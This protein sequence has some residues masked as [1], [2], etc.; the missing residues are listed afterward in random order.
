MLRSMPLAML[1]VAVVAVTAQP[2]FARSP[3]GP[4]KEVTGFKGFSWVGP[5]NHGW[6]YKT[7]TADEGPVRSGAEAD[8]FEIRAGD[9]GV[10]EGYDLCK[11]DREHVAWN[12]T[13]STKIGVPVAYSFSIYIPKDTPTSL[14]NVN[15]ILVEFR[16][17]GGGQINLSIELQEGNLVAV[18]GATEAKQTD[19]MHPPKPALWKRLMR[20]KPDMWIDFVLEAVWSHGKDGHLRLD[21][22]GRRAFSLDG[23][24]TAFKRAVH[25]Q[26]GLYRPY[27]SKA[28]APLPTQ[29][30]Y[31]DNIGKA[32]S[33]D[34]LPPLE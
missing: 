5:S 12:E 8:R 29:V 28:S 10:V 2:A 16:N 23:P 33:R 26:Y 31:Y 11:H 34:K 24:N 1:C 30:I 27:V 7:T 21:V 4:S 20:P 15:E 17:V 9:C 19:D 18:V 32:P 14:P 25:M 22:N 13:G 3:K 6:N